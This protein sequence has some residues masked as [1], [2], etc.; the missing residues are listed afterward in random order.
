MNYSIYIK[1]CQVIDLTIEDVN[2]RMLTNTKLNI[3]LTKWKN[4][5]DND[6]SWDQFKKL[7]NEY[8]F[9]FS[10]NDSKNGAVRRKPLSR[11]YFK[12]W[13]ILHDFEMFTSSSSSTSPFVTAHLAEGPGGFIESLCEYAKRYDIELDRIYGITLLSSEKK[14]P[15]WKLGNA[16]L[17]EFPI[18][19]NDVNDNNGDLYS[20]ENIEQFAQTVGGNLCTLVTADG[21]F[22]FSKDFNNQETSFYRLFLCEIYAAICIQKIG[23][24][25]L[26]KVFDLFQEDTI[27]LIACCKCF[28]DEMYIIKPNTSR[29]A[30]SEKYILFRCFTGF[31]TPEKLHVKDTLKR[32]VVD[33]DT[34]L[35]YVPKNVYDTI[36]DCVTKYNAYYTFRQISYIKKTLNLVKQKYIDENTYRNLIRNL[37]QQHTVYCERWCKKYNMITY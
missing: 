1:D 10:R 3:E 18:L 26:V 5:I 28:Y 21:G 32:Q 29:P 34:K 35:L 36:L 2:Q 24:D 31:D 14:V 7:T 19:V 20:I 4:N 23:G 33:P 13:E 27:R 12:M 30:N 16:L 15:N 9:I 25:F 11:S 6:P 22:D 37:T 17:K 8:E